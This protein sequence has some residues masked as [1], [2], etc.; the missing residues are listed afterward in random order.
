MRWPAAWPVRPLGE[1]VDILDS[2]RIPLNAK[3]RAQRLGEVPYYGATGRVGWIDQPL[4]DEPLVLLG[5]DGVQFFEANKQKAYLIDGPAWVNNHAHV[6]RARREV[7]RRFLGH[8]LNA[9]DYRGLANGT[10]RLK[11][12]QAA[13]KRIP[14]PVPPLDEQC[15]IID[16]LEDHLSR[17][18]AADAYLDTTRRR[19][20]AM[21]RSALAGCREGDL[22]PLAK[23]T[24]I[25]GGIQKQ[26]KRRPLDNA[27]PFLRVAN[28]TPRGLDL[29]DV[30]QVELFQGELSRLRL[31]RGDL[32]VVEGNGSASQIG[33]AALWDGSIDDCVHQNHLI[34][35]RPL[36]GLLP[37]YLEAVWNS[38]QNRAALTDIASSSSGLHTL[39]VS[40]LKLLSIPVPS[41]DRQRDLVAAVS[42]IRSARARL[43]SALAEASPR[44]AALRRSLLAA[45]FSGRLTERAPDVSHLGEMIGA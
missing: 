37:E 33:R 39:S 27:F 41:P 28:V 38:P 36:D 7:E 3:Q 32:L 44:S 2:R 29:A 1:I 35:V 30:H 40:K 11:L 13:M 34:R 6:L 16:L 14:V 5:E 26:Q 18:D 25:Q 4:F 19:L 20:D 15:R 42:E 8:Y 21:E 9:V 45:A 17:L 23:V 24:Q 31:L 12:T 43:G 10:T 22:W